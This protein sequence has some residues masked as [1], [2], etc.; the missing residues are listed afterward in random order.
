MFP[1]IALIGLGVAVYAYAS[2]QGGG[3]HVAS[4]TRH[5]HLVVRGHKLEVENRARRELR[6]FH[7][8]EMDLWAIRTYGARRRYDVLIG[9]GPTHLVFEEGTPG[10]D[11]LIDYLLQT[12]PPGTDLSRWGEAMETRRRAVFT[13]LDRRDPGLR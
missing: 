9:F 7:L 2:S 1:V 10:L 11:E 13:L 8:S 4:P 12:P 5:T 3:P 6:H